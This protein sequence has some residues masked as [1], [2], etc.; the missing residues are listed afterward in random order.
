LPKRLIQAPCDALLQLCDSVLDFRS[1]VFRLE[2]EKKKKR[3]EK[4]IL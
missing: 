4:V 3:E 1:N 2:K